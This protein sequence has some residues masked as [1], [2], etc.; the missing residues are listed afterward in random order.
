MPRLASALRT[1]WTRARWSVAP[2]PSLRQ[3]LMLIA[4][5]AILCLP[6]LRFLARPYPINQT[7]AY[8]DYWLLKGLDAGHSISSSLGWF[9]G[10][11]PERNGFYRPLTSV[12]LWLDYLLYGWNGRPYRLTNLFLYILTATALGPLICLFTSRRDFA[13]A[14]VAF[15]CLYPQG[16][17]EA[18]ILAFNPRGDLLC[19]LFY[20]GGLYSALRYARYREPR[21]A[22]WFAVC[23]TLALLSKEMALSLPLMA[24][25]TI[26]LASRLPRF[27]ALRSVPAL[28]AASA[29]VGLG[30]Y[31]AY[32]HAIPGRFAG[33]F[34][35][36]I[37][38]TWLMCAGTMLDD[39]T[40]LGL[41]V[42][43]MPQWADFITCYLPTSLLR[44]GIWLAA[45]AFIASRQWRLVAYYLLWSILTWLPLVTTHIHAHHYAYLPQL[46]R[47]MVSGPFLLML[48]EACRQKWQAQSSKKGAENLGA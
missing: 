13:V 44:L 4:L 29:A 21:H 2:R 14:S 30:W 18:V 19:G 41:W 23:F 47:A 11:W 15:F 42:R 32:R 27:R 25:A 28:L 45:L 16:G 1:C 20:L 39:L 12:S 35:K 6:N 43:A 26:L 3:L 8:D 10:E 36:I 46:N 48:V 40:V 22:G 31:L 38:S 34:P 9:H 37:A 33:G 5:S 17:S 7:V 24:I